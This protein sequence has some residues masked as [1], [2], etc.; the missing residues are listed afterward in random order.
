MLSRFIIIVG[1]IGALSVSLVASANT[2]YLG[3]VGDNPDKELREFQGLSQYLEKHVKDIG[4][5]NVGVVI[6]SNEKE[7]AALISQEK[8]HLY[9]DS[10]FPAITV[11]RLVGSRIFLRRWK[12]GV[13]QYRSVVFSRKDSG[14]DSFDA[15]KGKIIAFEEPFSTSS[16]FLPKAM[17]SS[18]GLSLVET[19]PGS[20]VPDNRIGYTFSDD[21]QNSMVWVLRKKVPVA[22]M[23]EQSFKKLA[24]KRLGDLKVIGTSAWVPR[25]V[26]S[27]SPGLSSQQ[28]K[29]IKAVLIHMEDTDEGRQVLQQFSNTTRFDDFDGDIEQHLSHIKRLIP[30]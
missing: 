20:L 14:I 21:D 7:M 19:S 28:V 16:Y 18:Q 2:L 23:S 27:H 13:S 11:E 3:S 6:T 12:K 5:D 17:I 24:K 1:V 9:I 15:M 26:V 29:V 10:P 22:A 8:V 30:R 4:F 25:H